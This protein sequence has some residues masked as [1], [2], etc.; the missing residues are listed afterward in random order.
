[1]AVP[2]EKILI[3]T[4]KGTSQHH[5][6][7]YLFPDKF[8]RTPD[9][10][11]NTIG[12]ALGEAVN[13][14]GKVVD[15]PVAERVTNGILMK[16]WRALLFTN[17]S[18]L[19]HQINR[20]GSKEDFQGEN[21]TGKLN[22][23]FGGSSARTEIGLR[24]EN[25]WNFSEHR[26][27]NA[28]PR[29]YVG[30]NIAELLGEKGKKSGFSLEYQDVIG[31]STQYSA[32][33]LNQVIIYNM[34]AMNEETG[35]MP[36]IA[37]QLRPYEIESKAET[38]WAAIKSMGR[39]TPMY[40]YL[41][42]EDTIQFNTNWF[43]KGKPGTPGFNPYWVINQC[44]KLKAWSMA[45]GYTASPPVLYIQWG[46]ADIFKDELWIL[47]SATYHLTNF[48]DKVVVKENTFNLKN[49]SGIP[50]K[51]VKLLDFGLVPFGA[52]QELIFKRVSSHNL[53]YPEIENFQEPQQNTP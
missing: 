48:S 35:E 51:H 50:E 43:M 16:G 10:Y 42:A 6:H 45:N 53:L 34:S 52:T 37:L 22:T 44:R 5:G 32:D 47:T 39:N 38:S 26:Q 49:N 4:P 3:P 18:G 36:F 13:I 23:G 12:R 30:H 21:I 31:K 25:K 1:M 28:T 24:E 11:T 19:T 14:Y 7:D 41:G 17:R 27:A 8:K 46:R 15:N 40:H 9:M 20:A 2:K 29:I 33:D